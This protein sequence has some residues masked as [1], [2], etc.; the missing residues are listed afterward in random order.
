VTSP[1]RTIRCDFCGLEFDPACTEEGC[2][3]CPLARGCSR[4]VCPRCGYEMLPEA[5][6]VSLI[7]QI[8]TRLQSFNH[9]RAK[10]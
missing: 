2:Q 5:R 10:E 6:L 8:R 9:M 3:G 7:R 4:I 1:S